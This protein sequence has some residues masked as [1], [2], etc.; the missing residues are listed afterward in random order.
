MNLHH[1]SP[2]DDRGQRVSCFGCGS[3]VDLSLC[4]ADLD[5]PAFKAYYCDRCVAEIDLKNA[6]EIASACGFNPSVRKERA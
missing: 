4:M 5:G 1:I 2:T 6:F 3:R